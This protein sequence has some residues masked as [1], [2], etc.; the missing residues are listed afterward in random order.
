M[1]NLYLSNR[2][3]SY[4][5][6]FCRCLS[7]ELN[8]E[9]CFQEGIPVTTGTDGGFPVRRWTLR[10]L[11]TLLAAF[12]PR[13]VFVPEFSA[14]AV[15]CLLLRKKYGY[16]VISTCDDSMDMIQ[17]HDFGWKHRLARR[18]IPGKL[19]EIIL[20]SPEVAGWYRT[21]FGKGLVMPILADER[22]TRPELERVLPLSDR[23]RPGPQPIVAF[24]GR[25]VG[26]KN[27][28]VLLR[29]FE[30]L[31]NRAQLVIIGD[32]PERAALEAQAPEGTLFTGMLAGD[33][34]LAWYNLIDILVLPSSQEAYGA[35]TGEALMAGASVIVSRKAGSS[36]LVREGENG[37]VI[38]PPD[39]AGLTD[40]IRRLL[41][42]LPVNRPLCLRENL[43]PYQF[44]DSIQSLLKEINS[45]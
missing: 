8:C 38:D 16:K 15:L 34:L 7:R 10:R 24:V 35:V 5:M 11:P 1:R 12:R 25:L 30:P 23:L 4:R 20:H 2:P 31:R 18:F 45:L 3:V 22:R 43:L 42:A 33:E 9:I 44:E 26:L 32:G 13:L 14:A 40:C 41:D 37:Y 28:P 21:H 27:V 36:S 29:A 19:D 39:E 17:G 6:D